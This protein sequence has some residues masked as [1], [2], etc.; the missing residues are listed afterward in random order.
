MTLN[1]SRAVA[2]LNVRIHPTFSDLIAD[3]QAVRYNQKGHPDKS[4]I[5]FDLGDA[6]LMGMFGLK[7]NKTVSGLVMTDD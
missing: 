1:A 4:L 2:E 6:F 7:E 5:S 3:L